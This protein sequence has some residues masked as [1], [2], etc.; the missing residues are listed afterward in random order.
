MIYF[1]TSGALVKKY[2]SEIGTDKVRA[3][4]NK[5]KK[6]FSSKITYAEVC[7]S[8]ARKHRDNEIEKRHYQRIWR[9]FINDWE[10]IILIEVQEELFPLI[11]R[12]VESYPLR[13]ADAIHLSSAIW[14]GEKIGQSLTFAASDNALL[15][16][17][18]N[19]GLVVINPEDD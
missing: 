17:A 10:A 6:V 18:R 12:L 7:A 16:A 8:F 19:E 11:R 15:S 9:S 4:L 2:I 13:G 3:L 14:I 5:E 1:D